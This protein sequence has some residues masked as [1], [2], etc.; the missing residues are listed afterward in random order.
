MA[1]A[2]RKKKPRLAAKPRFPFGFSRILQKNACNRVA[3]RIALVELNCSL[4]DSTT[5]ILPHNRWIRY[6]AAGAISLCVTGFFASGAAQ[7]ECGDYVMVGSH[8]AKGKSDHQSTPDSPK[9]CDGPNCSQRIPTPLAP[10]APAP[11]INPVEW[12]C[13]FIGLT[14]LFSRNASCR[15]DDVCVRPIRQPN[16][17]FHPPKQIG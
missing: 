13:L 6:L 16:S 11:T 8:A 2:E 3:D 1:N 7:A 14:D 4:I 5:M 17:I 12:A 10:S 9:P 15:P